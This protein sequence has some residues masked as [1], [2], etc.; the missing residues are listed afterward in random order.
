MDT[1]NV[2]Y[3]I[4]T[5][6]AVAV[7]LVM[8]WIAYTTPVTPPEKTLRV[9]TAAA[10]DHL[11][12]Q[13]RLNEEYRKVHPD[14]NVE[15]IAFPYQS[16]WRKLQFMIVA[17]IP[18]DTT[19]IEPPMVPRLIDLGAIEPLDD[20]IRNDGEFDPSALFPRCMDEGNW[21]NIQYAIPANVSPVCLWYNKDL[22]DKEGLAYPNRDWN[23]EDLVAAARKLT[24]DL[25]GDGITD[26][27]G[28]YTTYSH[29]NRFPCWVWM[30][31][32]EF[33]TGDQRR[34]TFDSPATM[35]GMKWIAD[36]AVKERVMPKWS[37]LSTIS[38]AS[39]F[40]SGRLAMTTESRFYL[41][42]FFLEKNR[43]IVRKFDWDVCELPHDKNRATTFVVGLNIIPRTA[44]P[45][46]KKI[47]WDY[48][49]FL[50][51][52]TGQNVIAEM[53]TA[54]PA[55]MSVAEK[56][57]H[58]PGIAPENDRAFLECIE[59]GRYLYYPFPAEAALMDARMDFMSA[60]NGN[61]DSDDVCRKA[62]Y[63]ITKSVDDHFR[64]HPEGR[65]PV[66]TKWVPFDKRAE[67]PVEP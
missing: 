55:R 19:S 67:S 8:G 5:A 32:G 11:K 50:T 34:C 62:A 22:F 27:Y 65:L 12:I 28:F 14:M 57:V 39:L 17:G 31:G 9:L 40:I 16:G 4:V 15:T 42:N 18:P 36:L 45:E 56:L 59:Y 53:N 23:L 26:Q 30:M 2:I 43:D 25:D 21:D 29:P 61:L 1:E 13:R 63:E 54:L 38:G 48:I 24:K 6:L 51:S 35:R 33:F 3:G 10:P 49:K 60:W 37:T 64:I 44:T 46:R 41:A 58:H 47:G 20:W 66:K 52:E 7:T